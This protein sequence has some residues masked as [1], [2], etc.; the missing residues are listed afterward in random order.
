[1]SID[2]KLA[3]LEIDIIE[4]KSQL[5]NAVGEREL[6]IRNQITATRIEKAALINSQN[7]LTGKLKS[8]F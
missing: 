5:V 7:N 6:A 4:L 3:E 1:M 8:D 2:A